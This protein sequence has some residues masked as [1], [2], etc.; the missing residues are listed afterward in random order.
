[1]NREQD[2]VAEF[3]AAFGATIGDTPELRDNELRAK[4]I[5]EEAV[6]TVAALGFHV[7]ANVEKHGQPGESLHRQLQYFEKSYEKPDFIE[8]ID[9]LCDLIYVILG[10]AVAAGIDLE[11]FFDEVHRSNM[12][13]VGGEKRADGKV[14]K[15][16]TFTPPD[17]Q[18]LLDFQ[19]GN[20]EDA[21]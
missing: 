2:M 1:M 17:L 16:K 15:P 8:V 18:P 9:G 12:S 14:L 6:E 20:A 7:W 3:H 21:A 19:I 10:T 11:P 5:M 13:K 4:L